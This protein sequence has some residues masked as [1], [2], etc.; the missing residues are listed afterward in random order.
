M[1]KKDD[2]SF[3]WR[4]QGKRFEI[5]EEDEGGIYDMVPIGG[6][7]LCVTRKN[8]HSIRLADSVDP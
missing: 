2:D 4:T 6:D 1:T 3:A 7:L 8:I 5:G